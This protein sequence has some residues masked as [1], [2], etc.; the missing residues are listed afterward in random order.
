MSRSLFV[1]LVIFSSAI[2][3]AQSSLGQSSEQSVGGW[4]MQDAA[5][6]TAP[7]SEISSAKF[8]PEKWYPATVPGTVLTTLVHNNVYPE[9]LYGENMRSIPESLN[10]TTYWYRTTFAVPTSYKG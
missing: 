7:A 8:R 6:V 9:P 2:S 10:K 1:F 5:K 4:I 3:L